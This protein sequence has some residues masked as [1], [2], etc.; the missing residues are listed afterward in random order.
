MPNTIK[1]GRISGNPLDGL[2]N[3]ICIEVRRVYDGCRENFNNR[4]YVVSVTVPPQAVAPF[5][6]VR[7]E[8][9]GQPTVTVMN[10]ILLS[11]GRT[12]ITANITVPI[13]VTFTDANQNAFTSLSDIILQREVVLSVP[14]NTVAPYTLEVFSAFESRIGNFLSDTSVSVTGCLVLIYKIIVISDVLVPTYGNCEYPECNNRQEVCEAF[15]SRPL[16]P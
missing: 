4:T 8:S 15:L 3:R 11:S 10:S 5:T 13:I 16:F 14:Q 9:N 2:C 12:R 6:F 1:S 7:A